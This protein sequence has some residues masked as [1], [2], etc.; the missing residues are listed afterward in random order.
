MTFPWDS[1][2][3]EGYSGLVCWYA[4]RYHLRLDQAQ[5]FISHPDYQDFFEAC[6]DLA[7]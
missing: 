7:R 6:C 5:F 2:G 4:E 3:R 1:P